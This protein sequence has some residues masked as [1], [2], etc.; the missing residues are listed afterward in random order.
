[1]RAKQVLASNKDGFVF[2][3]IPTIPINIIKN[4]IGILI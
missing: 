4:I 1:M 3:T 2:W